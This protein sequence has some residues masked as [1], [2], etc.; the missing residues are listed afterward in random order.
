MTTHET[1]PV[2]VLT[3]KVKNL[4]AEAVDRKKHVETLEKVEWEATIRARRAYKALPPPDKLRLL[5][6]YM[7]KLFPEDPEPDV[8]TDLRAWATEIEAAQAEGPW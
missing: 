4:E 2:C 6:D 1:C 3:A 8:Q 7:D 5:A